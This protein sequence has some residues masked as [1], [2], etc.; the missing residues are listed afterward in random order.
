VSKDLLALFSFIDFLLTG[1]IRGLPRQHIVYLEI[2]HPEWGKGT[3]H[4]LG[5]NS[6]FA[7][8]IKQND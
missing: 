1:G 6:Y 7:E 5:V 8:G 3:V 4:T 2:E